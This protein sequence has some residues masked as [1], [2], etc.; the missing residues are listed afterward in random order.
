MD[1]YRKVIYICFC[2]IIMISISLHLTKLNFLKYLNNNSID[3]LGKSIFK[4]QC[5]QNTY[6]SFGGCLCNSQNENYII[7]SR[8]GNKHK[9]GF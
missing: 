5:C 6:S 9:I 8:G 2:L 1:I 7:H 4:P 3:L